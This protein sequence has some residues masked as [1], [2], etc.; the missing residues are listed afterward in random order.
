M[1]S[2]VALLPDG[3]AKASA[4]KAAKLITATP[5]AVPLLAYVVPVDSSTNSS[6]QGRPKCDLC[7]KLGFNHHHRREWCYCD[8]A[9]KVF[10]PEVL[11]QRIK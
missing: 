4:T 11:E 5:Q 6:T 9:S 1:L 2:G 7:S 10:K 3:S 8:P